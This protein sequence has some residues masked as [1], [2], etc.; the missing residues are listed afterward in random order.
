LIP[1]ANPT[2]AT[3]NK[4]AVNIYSATNRMERFIFKIYFSLM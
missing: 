4:I 1:G 2:I 3:C